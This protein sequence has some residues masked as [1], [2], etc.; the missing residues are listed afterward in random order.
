MEAEVLAL[1]FDLFSMVTSG[2]RRQWQQWEV[3]SHGMRH[4]NNKG[5]LKVNRR[6]SRWK[7]QSQTYLDETKIHECKKAYLTY[8]FVK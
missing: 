6:A 7:T 5:N 1:E 3:R 8:S 4:Y 2:G